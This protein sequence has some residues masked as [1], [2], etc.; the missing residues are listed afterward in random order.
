MGQHEARQFMTEELE[1]ATNYFDEKNLI[2]CGRLGL[3]YKG[4]LQDGTIVAIKRRAGIPQQE[5][6]EEVS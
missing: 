1:Q 4:L 2:G 6:V 3:V 5:F